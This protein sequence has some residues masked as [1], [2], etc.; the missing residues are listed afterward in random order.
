MQSNIRAATAVAMPD[1]FF[2]SNLNSSLRLQQV[3][4]FGHPR[5]VTGESHRPLSSAFAALQF[6]PLIG[7][8]ICSDRFFQ[9]KPPASPPPNSM[10]G[11]G[12]FFHI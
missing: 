4:E 1:D 7:L 2:S 3:L 6:I 11:A 5:A 12:A 8:T 10:G 9:K